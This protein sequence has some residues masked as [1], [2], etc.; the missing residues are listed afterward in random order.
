MEDN[1]PWLAV[2]TIAVLGAQHPL[3]KHPKNLLPKF[4]PDNDVTPEDHIKQFMLSLRL[5]DMQHE[6]VP[7]DLLHHGNSLKMLS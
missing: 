6:D 2:D 4:D 3:P 7:Q 1:K 5:M